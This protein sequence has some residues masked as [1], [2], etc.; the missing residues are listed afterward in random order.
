MGGINRQAL[1]I[2]DA[3]VYQEVFRLYISMYDASIVYISHSIKHF[4]C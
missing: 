4:V 2:D 1:V 3:T